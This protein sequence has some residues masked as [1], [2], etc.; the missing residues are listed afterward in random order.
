V[1][2]ADEPLRSAFGEILEGMVQRV[3]GAVGAVFADWEGESIDYFAHVPPMEI[4]LAGAHWGVV[5]GHA[6]EASARLGGGTVEEIVVVCAE[7]YVL[8][9]TVGDHYFVVLQ[10]RRGPLHLGLARRELERGVRSLLG[11]M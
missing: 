11:E 2:I 8:V 10:G 4:R 9:R 3:P 5:L 1:T 6:G 7:A